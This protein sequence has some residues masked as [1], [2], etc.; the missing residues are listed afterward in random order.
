MG[1]GP[2]MAASLVLKSGYRGILG[3]LIEV[4]VLGSVLR[5]QE[6]GTDRTL[7]IKMTLA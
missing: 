7:S 4:Q 5:I 1:D 3:T 2:E 6:F